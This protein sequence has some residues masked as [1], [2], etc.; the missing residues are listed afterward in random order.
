M[1]K[2]RIAAPWFLACSFLGVMTLLLS[3][4][5]SAA[6]NPGA[7]DMPPSME[8]QRSRNEFVQKFHR[9]YLNTTPGDANLLRILIEGS[10]AKRGVEVGTSTGYGAMVMGLGFERNKGQLTSV[11]IDPKAVKTA[12]ENIAK[13]QLEKV[14]TIVEGDA[15]QVLPKLEGQFDFV[16]IDA[17]KKDYFKYFKALEPKLKPGSIVVADNVIKS[18]AAMPDFLNAVQN[19]PDYHTVII[20]RVGRKGRRH[21]RELQSEVVGQIAEGSPCVTLV[22]PS[23][24]SSVWALRSWLRRAVRLQVMR[25][26]DP[27]WGFLLL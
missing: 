5:A 27:K 7:Q 9:I 1:K 21:V 17:V 3:Q 12:R 18:G 13:M 10:K 19:S 4:L 24:G 22:E 6:D 16:F 11:D 8:L 14:V 15:L 25:R 23:R 26:R 2:S 20:R